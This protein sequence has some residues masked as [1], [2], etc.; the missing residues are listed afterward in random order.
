MSNFIVGLTG[1]IGSGKST[2]SQFFRQQGIDVIDAD[3]TA[4]AVVEP[5]TPALLKIIT[6][7]GSDIVDQNHQLDRH[8]LRAAIFDQ[9]KQKLWLE[10]LLHPAIRQHMLHQAQI[11]SSPYVIFEVPLL[12]ESDF[13]KL[14]DR[15]LVVDVP[16]ELQIERTIARDGS[17]LELVNKI[18]ASQ[19]TREQRIAAADD[20]IDNS[21][22]IEM[23]QSQLV[24]LQNTY[25]RLASAK[26][27]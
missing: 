2:I 1:G 14:V 24:S 18:I 17:N 26:I 11:S 3:Q 27:D 7:F 15:I 20:V 25:L 8:K 10:Q 19:A 16:I 5:G 9:P 21:Q 22:P 23:Q 4:R 6:H 12:I 13:K